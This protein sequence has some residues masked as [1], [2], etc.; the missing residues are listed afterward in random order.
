MVEIGTRPK[1]LGQEP[2]EDQTMEM[3]MMKM[4]RMM[5]EGKAGETESLP[6]KEDGTRDP[7]TM[8]GRKKRIG[9]LAY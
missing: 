4:T 7:Q 3:M 2:P 8:R 1:T 9:F 5:T 6:I